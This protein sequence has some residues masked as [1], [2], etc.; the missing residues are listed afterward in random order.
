MKKLFVL[1]M[2]FV[3]SGCAC[4]NS[5]DSG[6]PEVIY[7]TSEARVA[8]SAADLNCD[9]IEGNTCYRYIR[10]QRRVEYVEPRREVIRYREPTTYRYVRTTCG[11]SCDTCNV[12]GSAITAGD[13]SCAPKIRTTREPV[14]I[15]YKKTTYKT[16]YEPKTTSSVTYEKVPYSERQVRRDYIEVD[17]NE[18]IVVE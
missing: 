13:S 14:E 15:V 2:M 18:E 10:R 1:S 11:S 9:F 4:F 16:V 6:E 5:D 17:N 7:K 12:S 8:G 3:L